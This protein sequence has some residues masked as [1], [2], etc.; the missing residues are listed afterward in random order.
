MAS[1]FAALL[2]AGGLEV[3]MLATWEENITALTE[4]G[5]T[6]IDQGG[7]EKQYPITVTSSTEECSGT[8]FAIVLVKSYQTAAAA[9]RLRECLAVD[10]FVLTLQNGLGNQEILAQYLGEERV[11]LGV[12]T[13]GATLM[14]PGVVRM[15]GEG[16]ISIGE[17]DNVDLPVEVLMQAGFE[18]EV[19]PDASSL[20][21]GKLV[22]NAAINPLTALLGV[23][24]GA[25]L[26]N[27]DSHQLMNLIAIETAQVAE[28][29]QISLP[30]PDPVEAVDAVA[31]KTASN[32][33]S[34]YIDLH[35]GTSTEV[36]AINGA[37]VDAGERVG[38]PTKYNRLLW[39]LVKATS[40]IRNLS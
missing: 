23:R 3:K 12:T 19:V 27:P 13:L 38:A 39:L 31:R 26:E 14:G 5:V 25:L 15:G 6:F 16:G 34:M 17:H 35:R 9:E 30:Y 36:D 20:V 37:V 40:Q 22:I 11:I 28:A 24:N 7:S 8:Q 1:L 2:S 32:F 21:W 18:V 10:G 33:S 29:M 4:R